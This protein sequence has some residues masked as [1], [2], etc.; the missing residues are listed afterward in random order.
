MNMTANQYKQ[1][2]NERARVLR[3]N[4]T[5]AEA[6]MWQQLRDHKFKNTKFFRQKP[7]L[8]LANNRVYFFITDFYCHKYSLIIEVDGDIHDKKEQQEYDSMREETLKEMGCKIL[9]FKNEEVMK[10][11]ESVVKKLEGYI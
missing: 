4:Q 2:I 8:F 9:R 10:N 6:V 5:P 7:I 3:K 1:I 11:T